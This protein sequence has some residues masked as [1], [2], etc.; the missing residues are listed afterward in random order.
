MLKSDAVSPESDD[1]SPADTAAEGGDLDDNADGTTV[2]GDE[3][4]DDNEPE[5]PPM[6]RDFR[7]G[8]AEPTSRGLKFHSLHH[9]RHGERQVQSSPARPGNTRNTAV[10][11][12]LTPKPI[13][14]QL[15]PSPQSLK[16][17]LD[18]A[19]ATTFSREVI[20]LPTFVRRSPR[21]NKI[22]DVFAGPLETAALVTVDGAEKE[23]LAPVSLLHDDLDG[24]F[25]GDLDD[26]MPP[27]STP[28]PKRRSERLLFKTPGK[29]PS[30]D[31]GDKMSPNVQRTPGA[32]RTPR[33]TQS[34]TKKLLDDIEKAPNPA[35][36]TPISRLI[37]DS[38]EGNRGESLR[39]SQTPQPGSGRSRRTPAKSTNQDSADFFDFPDLPSL[40][41]SSPM[42][43]GLMN[44]LE[45]SEMTTD[46]LT[47]DYNDVFNTDMQMPSSPPQ[48]YFDY[49]DGKNDLNGS[50]WAEI[51]MQDN[52]HSVYP[53][54]LG[55]SDVH[56]VD[57][58]HGTPRRSPRKHAA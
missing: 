11:I 34:F 8:S 26:M 7:G 46:H 50:M 17:K 52:N 32:S 9:T 53:P 41:G 45:F 35:E 30:R 33:D 44:A 38:W 49:L 36:M 21:L 23:N 14:R 3:G 57:A 27:P 13:R 48:G 55:G 12:D 37:H 31:F 19:A 39:Y 5:L 6:P 29:T 22:R 54:V 58:S 56:H 18:A 24:L 15:F 2:N 51:E 10:E 4:N 16:N 1:S 47:T 42:R 20:E 25:N 28:T 43:A 40:K